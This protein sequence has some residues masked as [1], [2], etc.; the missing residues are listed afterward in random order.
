MTLGLRIG[1]SVSTIRFHSKSLSAPKLMSRPTDIPVAFRQLS[2]CDSSRDV[3]RSM[4]LISVMIFSQYIKSGLKN[5][6]S[7]VPLQSIW[8]L[9]ADCWAV[10]A[11]RIRSPMLPQIASLN[12]G[13]SWLYTSIAVPMIAYTSSLNNSSAI[14]PPSIQKKPISSKEISADQRRL[15]D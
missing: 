8:I 14:L 4:A 9:V 10:S 12:P 15:A 5:C 6:F 2:N 13:P 7:V 1:F 3:K 11:I